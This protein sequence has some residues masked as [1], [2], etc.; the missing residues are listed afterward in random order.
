M[1]TSNTMRSSFFFAI[2]IIFQHSTAA[3][4]FMMLIGKFELWSVKFN[5]IIK[6]VVLIISTRTCEP[7]I[8]YELSG[9]S[10]W[11]QKFPWRRRSNSNLSAIWSRNSIIILHSFNQTIHNNSFITSLWKFRFTQGFF[12]SLTVI[13]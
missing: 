7:T 10:T 2:T 6:R 13:F 1:K 12:N 5:V 9:N 8:G 11:L 3:S 4:A